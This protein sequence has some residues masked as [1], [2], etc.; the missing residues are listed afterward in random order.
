MSAVP[1]LRRLI[2]SSRAVGR[3]LSDAKHDILAVSRRNNGMD[4][5]S[6]ILWSAGDHYLQ[7]LEGPAESVDT[8]FDR[9]RADPR[10][11]DIHILD[12]RSVDARQFGDWAM[13]GMPGDHPEDARERLRMMLRNADAD[14][15][16][17]F[18]A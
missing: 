14:V 9:I 2:Y 10:H 1:P 18:G 12:D 4:G 15:V 11:T 6:G 3:D 17:F 16:R 7:V 13:A 8:A 5:I